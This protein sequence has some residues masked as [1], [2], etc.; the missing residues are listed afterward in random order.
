MEVKEIVLA[1]LEQN[2]FDGLF[3]SDISCGC[4]KEDLEPC[5]QMS[6]NCVVGHKVK[7][8]CSENCDWHIGEKEK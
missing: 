4:L 3:N 1:Y 7:C 6:S 5:G 2:G 8:D